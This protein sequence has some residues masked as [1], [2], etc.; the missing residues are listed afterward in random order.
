MIY[1]TILCLG[2]SLT[3]PARC[4]YFWGFPQFMA[5]K[6]REDLNEDVFVV[7]KGVNGETSSDLLFR[8]YDVIKEYPDVSVVT[9]IIG[10][11][12]TKINLPLWVYEKNI[13]QIVRIAKMFDK[14]VVL[15]TLPLI[16]SYGQPSFSAC[17]DEIRKKYNKAI[18]RISKREKVSV[19]RVDMAI[20]HN[21]L[22]DGLHFS[23][24]GCR[25]V[26][27]LFAEKMKELR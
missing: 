24:N 19:V 2:D 6:I 21:E 14:K 17:C 4:D 5:W 10:T 7:N 8:A 15:G 16:R 9:V 3:Y 22:V 11:N 23:T 26:G 13:F 1:H 27:R 12:D 20:T 25:I 18:I